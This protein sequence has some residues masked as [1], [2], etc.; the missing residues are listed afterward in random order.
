MVETIA[1][2]AANAQRAMSAA[3]ARRVSAVV[4]RN[5]PRRRVASVARARG[6]SSGDSPSTA[7][8]TLDNMG[9]SLGPIGLTIG[10]SA[11]AD[12]D[13]EVAAERRD[14]DAADGAQAPES[15]SSL[16][17]S[18]WR[19]MYEE[20]DGTVSLWAEDEYNAASRV[21]GGRAYPERVAT[22]ESLSFGTGGT[23]EGTTGGAEVGAVHHNVHIL[24]RDG[25]TVEV[26]VPSD[27]YIFY[28]AEDRGL[29]LPHAC[30]MGCCTACAVKVKKGKLR[31]T[32]ALGVSK[33][34]KEKGY[35]LMCVSFPESDL[36]LELA[37]E[38]EVYDIQFGE[39]FQRMAVDPTNKDFVERD[40]FALELADMDE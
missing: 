24:D 22:S 35:A 21:P 11:P 33:P 15:I 1:N 27:R 13:D 23:G 25:S 18:A 6:S 10:E 34:L 31:Q 20:A 39:A 30:R 12:L 26:S 29:D 9:L 16:T 36:E 4:Q 37:D 3:F 14:G 38:D 2:P 8:S 19:E 40:D 7:T 32:Q 5:R 28:E 17:T